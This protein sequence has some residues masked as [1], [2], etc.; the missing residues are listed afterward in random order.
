M[1][2]K[3][4]RILKLYGMER[5]KVKQPFAIFDT[6]T[7]ENLGVGLMSQC[8]HKVEDMGWIIQSDYPTILGECYVKGVKST[9]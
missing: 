4:V 9:A 5:G 2:V 6:V 8:I 7:N 3:T 1:T